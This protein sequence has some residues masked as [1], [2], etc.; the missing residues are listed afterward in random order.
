MSITEGKK[1]CKWTRQFQTWNAN[2]TLS[3]Q[4]LLNYSVNP[5]MGEVKITS[6]DDTKQHVGVI[7]HT[8]SSGLG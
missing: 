3:A 1:T 4:Y 2:K 7:L 6:M 8:S 5:M